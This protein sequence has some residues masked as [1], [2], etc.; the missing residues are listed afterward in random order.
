LSAQALDDELDGRQ[1]L[2]VVAER[3]SNVK[4]AVSDLKVEMKTDGA[5]IR[6][7]MRTGFRELDARLERHEA[8]LTSLETDRAK[9]QGGLSFGR[10]VFPTLSAAVGAAAG[11]LGKSQ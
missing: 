5:A 7:E 3:V 2:A 11:W 10:W 8:R 1:L 6:D 9:A 4:E